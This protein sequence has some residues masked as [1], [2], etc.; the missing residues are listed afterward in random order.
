[1]HNDSSCLKTRS[2]LR[3][4][5]KTEVRDLLRDLERIAKSKLSTQQKVDQMNVE[6]LRL[7]RERAN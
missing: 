7:L 4:K 1:M 3:V 6:M 2:N 5:T